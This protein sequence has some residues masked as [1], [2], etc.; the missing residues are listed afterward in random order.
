MSQYTKVFIHYDKEI[1]F[2]FFFFSYLDNLKSTNLTTITQRTSPTATPKNT[3]HHYKSDAISISSKKI[4]SSPNKTHHRHRPIK[5]S[6]SSSSL[7]SVNS[8]KTHRY[9]SPKQHRIVPYHNSNS[10]DV[11]YQPKKS[12]STRNESSQTSDEI[13]IM[14]NEQEQ[15]D[16]QFLLEQFSDQ[17]PKN[18][19]QAPLDQIKDFYEQKRSSSRKLLLPMTN[20]FDKDFRRKRTDLTPAIKSIQTFDENIYRLF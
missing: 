19:L 3:S 20:I 4:F 16:D 10:E 15:T 8:E 11:K 12:S 7:T 18:F 5:P 1:I 14:K 13:R 6:S 2:I 17:T 9:S